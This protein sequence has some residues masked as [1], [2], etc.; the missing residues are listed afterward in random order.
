MTSGV[1]DITAVFCNITIVVVYNLQNP[2]MKNIHTCM[3]DHIHNGKFVLH[4]GAVKT[5]SD[6]QI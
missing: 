5:N 2:K 3:F 6:R 4:L 1:D